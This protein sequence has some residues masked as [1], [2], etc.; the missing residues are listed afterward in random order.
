MHVDGA[1][2]DGDGSA[3]EDGDEE[4]EDEY[5][6]EADDIDVSHQPTEDANGTK[7]SKEAKVTFEDTPQ[8]A[9]SRLS[10]MRQHLLLLCE[11]R[12]SFARHCGRGLWTVD[13]RPLLR[14]LQEME[15]DAAMDHRVG[16]YG[17]RLARILRE[18]GKLDEKTL[19]GFAMMKKG[20][21]QNKTAQMQLHGFAEVQEVPR[22][23]SRQVNRTMFFWYCSLERAFAQ[24]LD[25]TYK[26]MLRALQVREQQRQE[27]EEVL[28][29][30]ERPDVKG[31]EEETMEKKYLDKY[32]KYRDM[33]KTL[34]G[35]ALKMDDTVAILRDY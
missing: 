32:E 8:T 33:E 22:D 30:V 1:E 9:E 7:E 25:N 19:P 6:S 12:L 16:R 15:L 10:Q 35:Q 13:F 4:E 3:D 23:N 29:F 2:A 27:N 20:D 34:V 26:A 18:N 28:A 31:R 24:Q 17:L 21:V 14:K 11:N 5:D